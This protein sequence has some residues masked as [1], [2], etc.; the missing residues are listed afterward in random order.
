M[1]K[2]TFYRQHWRAT[3]KERHSCEICKDLAIN[4]WS[5][6]EADGMVTKVTWVCDT[7]KDL[8]SEALA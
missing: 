5:D 7:H 8:T 3:A 1:S 6:E 4:A 2:K